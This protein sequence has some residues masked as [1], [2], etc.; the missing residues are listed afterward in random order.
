MI[1]TSAGPETATL[2]EARESRHSFDAL[3]HF[4]TYIS[5]HEVNEKK[6]LQCVKSGICNRNH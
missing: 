2:K 1:V 4:T 3:R 5:E 6:N